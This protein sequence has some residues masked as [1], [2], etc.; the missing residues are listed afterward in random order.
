ML[1]LALTFGWVMSSIIIW[2]NTH[3]TDPTQSRI[4]LP[5]DTV[6]IE[7]MLL[8]QDILLYSYLLWI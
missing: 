5:S 3:E 4:K 2:L 7:Q 1:Q 8:M 6:K